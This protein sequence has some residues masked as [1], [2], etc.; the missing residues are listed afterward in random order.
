MWL[1][2]NPLSPLCTTFY[3]FIKKIKEKKKKEK[4]TNYILGKKAL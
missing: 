1:S 3:Q 4:E 2:G